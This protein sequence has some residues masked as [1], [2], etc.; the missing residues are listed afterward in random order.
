MPPTFNVFVSHAAEDAAVAKTLKAQLEAAVPGARLFVSAEDIRL[1]GDWRREIDEALDAAR[2]LLV[3]CT[4]RSVHNRWLHF[5]SGAGWARRVGNER[6]AVIPICHNGVFPSTL[7]DPLRAFQGLS[8]ESP[9]DCRRLADRLAAAV[10]EQ[11]APAFDFAAMVRALAP[12][13]PQRQQRIGVDLSHRQAEWPL[14]PPFASTPM[15]D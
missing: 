10:H 4:P 12:T 11:V 6:I 3:L 8:L 2:A 7:D 5:E 15:H 14:R 9:D 1:G 13:R